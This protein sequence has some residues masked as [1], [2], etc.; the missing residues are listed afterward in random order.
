MSDFIIPD[1]DILLDEDVFS[2][3]SSFESFDDEEDELVSDYNPD[4]WN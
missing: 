2:D 3:S 1:D 4:D